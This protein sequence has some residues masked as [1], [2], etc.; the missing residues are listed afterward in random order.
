MT[1][2]LEE[3]FISAA[4]PGKPEDVRRLTAKLAKDGEPNNE[5]MLDAIRMTLDS[6]GD[7]VGEH[8]ERALLVLL[9]AKRQ[10]V[11]F[12]A[13]RAAL[14]T[15]LKKLSKTSVNRA[16]VLTA[17]GIRDS[18]TKLSEVHSRF[19]RLCKMAEGRLCFRTNSTQW[20]QIAAVDA[21]TGTVTLASLRG[22]KIQ[23]IKLSAALES[24]L[25]FAPDDVLRKELAAME[26]GKAS[27]TANAFA[28]LAEQCAGEPVDEKLLQTSLR[29]IMIPAGMTSPGFDKWW[30]AAHVVE[31]EPDETVD[32]GAVENARGHHELNALLHKCK[33]AVELSPA[34]LK[35][36]AI[37]SSGITAKTPPK[38]FGQW[39]ENICFIGQNLSDDD[40]KTLLPSHP[41]AVERAW[42]NV[43]SEELMA[44]RMTWATLKKSL[45]PVWA[46]C[47]KVAKGPEYLA[48]LV[49]ALPWR[50][51]P[52]VMEVI[53]A[54]LLHQR[55]ESITRLTPEALLWIWKQR[56]EEIPSLWARLDFINVVHS[57]TDKEEGAVWQEAV[58]ELKKAMLNDA[59][60]H[61]AVI[62]EN[63]EAYFSD[64]LEILSHNAVITASERQSLVVKMAREFPV[65]KVAIESGNARNLLSRDDTTNR[66][67]TSSPETHVTSIRSFKRRTAELKEII[68]KHI[69]EN[70][71]AIAHA[72]SYGDLRENAEFSAAKERQAFLNEQKI[73]LETQLTTTQT[74]DFADVV[75]KDTVVIGSTVQLQYPNDKIETYYVL[76]AWDSEPQ[77]NYISYQ[78]ALGKALISKKLNQ[79]ITVPGDKTCVIKSIL[80]LP[81][82]IQAELAE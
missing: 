55:L 59:K 63:S 67:I 23:D 73:L 20:C 58:K 40:L 47:A 50:A 32:G 21:I 43:D 4:E 60:F 49:L 39:A 24:L 33:G 48:E 25:I 51:W 11:D 76:G 42:P 46:R 15:A 62:K 13:L 7:S 37:L 82:K 57:L 36:I 81:A 80:P 27:T 45:L 61:R 6:W 65:L 56:P 64:C 10:D 30:T 31:E 28:Q 18:S 77:K 8:E 9:L 19:H 12:P 75:I 66:Q 38:I 17:L 72:R 5:T 68:S 70:T 22:K 35:K 14:P 52:P 1:P 79:T 26:N 34:G 16:T 29:N 53:P 2:E 78:T 69:P 54:A 71:I 3:L 41:D 44:A 74:T